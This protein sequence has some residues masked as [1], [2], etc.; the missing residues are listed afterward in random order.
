[1][2]GVFKRNVNP[3][4][5]AVAILLV[6]GGVQWWW[7][8]ALV[9]KRAGR[10]PGGGPR[11]GP[12]MGPSPLLIKGREDVQIGTLS[13][14]PDPGYVDGPGHMARFDGPTGLA[15]DRDGSLLVADTRNHRI[16][17]VDSRGITTTVSGSDAGYR[18]GPAAEALFNAPCGIRS[19]PAGSTIILDAGNFRIRRLSGGV[20]STVAEFPDAKS[21]NQKFFSG[22]R[23]SGLKVLPPSGESEPGL[24]LKS[25]HSERVLRT[26]G[27]TLAL[28]DNHSALFTLRDD[29]AEVVAG[30]FTP[31]LRME[32]WLDGPGNESRIGRVGGLAAAD[33]RT[34]YL[35]DT[36]NNAI[37][38]VTFTEGE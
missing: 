15:V 27:R 12:P 13:G 28:D 22:Q 38:K 29:G 4:I 3:R 24:E 31:K 16:R 36:T 30:I 18:D 14:A 35:A 33:S 17:R 7:W 20:V 19:E 25:V 1:M 10:P 11:G 32:G 34:V 6:L 5:V 26:P 21:A 37:R 23:L 8:S 9:A 2:T